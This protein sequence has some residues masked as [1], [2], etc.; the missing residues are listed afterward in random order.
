MHP[1]HEN[2]APLVKDCSACHFS[3]STNK[4]QKLPSLFKP[5]ECFD[6]NLGTVRS[7]IF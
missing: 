4:L 1:K 2:L 6:D 7:L 3:C 5:G